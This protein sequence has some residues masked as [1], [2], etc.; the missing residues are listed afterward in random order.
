MP[1]VLCIRWRP[2]PESANVR[3]N[4]SSLVAASCS[5]KSVLVEREGLARFTKQLRQNRRGCAIVR[6]DLKT[7]DRSCSPA[8][9]SP[10]DR[11]STAG[12]PSLLGDRK[13]KK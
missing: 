3:Q 2:E 6:Q 8:A 13:L 12:L 11:T 5:G 9:K 10:D 7:A 4:D 1:G